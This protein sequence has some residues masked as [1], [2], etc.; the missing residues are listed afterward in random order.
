MQNVI[1]SNVVAKCVHESASDIW[2][3]RMRWGVIKRDGRERENKGERRRERK[4]AK[5]EKRINRDIGK[6]KKRNKE[7]KRKR[8]KYQNI[9]ER[10]GEFEGVKLKRKKVRRWPGGNKSKTETKKNNE[11]E[12]E[13]ERERD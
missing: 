9:N 6:Y 10:I 3:Y 11:R 1:G 5:W 4:W 12:R 13:R 7:F 8:E 2:N